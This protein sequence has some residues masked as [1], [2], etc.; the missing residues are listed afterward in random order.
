MIDRSF[1]DK[2]GPWAVV[3]GASEGLGAAFAA[4]LAARGLN[5][6][7]LA[8]RG[9]A[10]AEVAASL[11]GPVEVRTAA[12]DLG[13]ADLAEQLTALCAEFDVGL[14]VYNAAYS[15]VG[16]FLEQSL[17]DKQRILDVNCRGPMIAAHVFGERLVRRG[18]GG[19]LLMSSLTAFWGSPFVAGYG[20]SKAFNLSLG[21]ALWYELGPQGVDVLV[22]CAGAT[23]TPGFLRS[24]GPGGP[25]SMAP[26]DV[27]EEALN[28]LGGGPSMV[29]GR[30]NRFAALLLNRLAPRRRAVQVMGGQTARLIR[31]SRG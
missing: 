29:P 15:Q 9:E 12:I 13:R 27:A 21:E 22:C 24:S 2:Y 3:A 4:A 7:L 23:A 20:A 14:C 6:L 16:S 1:A 28:A 11:R 25:R 17:A 8:R 10:L 19:I 31:E 5:L 18:R 30:F 26:A